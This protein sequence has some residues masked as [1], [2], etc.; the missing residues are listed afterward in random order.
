MIPL[1]PNSRPGGNASAPPISWSLAA[2]TLI[3]AAYG[4]LGRLSIDWTGAVTIACPAW[5]PAGLAFA[6]IYRFG[7]RLVPGVFL[8]GLILN[9]LNVLELGQ[10]T[11]GQ[12]ITPAVTSMGS[13]AEAL[14]CAACLRRLQGPILLPQ[15]PTRLAFLFSCWFLACLLCGLVGV[16]LLQQLIGLD[17]PSMSQTLIWAQGDL[18]GI[19]I[20]VL[21][22][23]SFMELT[24]RDDKSEARTL[25]VYCL[26]QGCLIAPLLVDTGPFVSAAL[27]AL[28]LIVLTFAQRQLSLLWLGPVT[29]GTVLT[30]AMFVAHGLRLGTPAEVSKTTAIF[31]LAGILATIH[32]VIVVFRAD[33]KRVREIKNPMHNCEANSFDPGPDLRKATFAVT[34]I[35]TGA[36]AVSAG[37]SRAEKD[38]NREARNQSLSTLCEVLMKECE[39]LE[40]RLS[41]LCSLV[42]LLSNAIKFTPEGGAVGMKSNS[43]SGTPALESERKAIPRFSSVSLNLT[44]ACRGRM[45][46]LGLGWPL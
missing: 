36:M 11:S 28:T 41:A 10:I 31:A 24:R 22:L 12:L 3:A 44:Q 8:G 33:L 42:N 5:L 26:I 4:L 16:L 27:L 6:A 25:I 9:L 2:N 32:A 20:A 29:A 40:L 35:L 14:L 18:W 45:A 46:A 30:I 7:A 21:L 43:W 23:R 37:L 13:C 15:S 38:R 1:R 39:Q 34:L 19:L 17:L